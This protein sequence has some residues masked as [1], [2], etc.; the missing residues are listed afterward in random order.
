MQAKSLTDSKV[1]CKENAGSVWKR[2]QKQGVL[3]YA[4]PYWPIWNELAMDLV[5]E[6]E[7]K[8]V[9]NIG[10]WFW[11]SGERRVQSCFESI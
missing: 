2:G 3:K 6:K 1:G 4:H 11:T 10:S 9:L 7:K 8:E 5:P